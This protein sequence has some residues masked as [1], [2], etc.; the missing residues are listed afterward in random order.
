MRYPNTLDIALQYSL[1]ALRYCLHSDPGTL[2]EA[3]L[4]AVSVSFGF[5]IVPNTYQ[6]HARSPNHTA[7][8]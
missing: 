3:P 4:L 2:R 1:A 7:G 5:S 8:R 6:N